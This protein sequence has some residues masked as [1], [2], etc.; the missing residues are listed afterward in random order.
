MRKIITSSLLFL[1]AINPFWSKAQ[2]IIW[3]TDDDA[4]EITSKGDTDGFNIQRNGHL[5]TLDGI[6]SNTVNISNKTEADVEVK[7]LQLTTGQTVNWQNLASG[8]TTELADL[9]SISQ[10]EKGEWKLWERVT[11]FIA[12]SD[13]YTRNQ[14]QN[15]QQEEVNIRIAKREETLCEKA[16]GINFITPLWTIYGKRENIDIRWSSKYPIT[17]VKLLDVSK[18]ETVLSIDQLAFY[19]LHYA[20]LDSDVKEKLI[21]GRKYELIVSVKN[22]D[23]E[24]VSAS[25]RFSLKKELVFSPLMKRKFAKSRF[26]FIWE[27]KYPVTEILFIDE[28]GQDTLF[29]E[30]EVA[31][32]DNSFKLTENQDKYQIDHQN[33]GKMIDLKHGNHYKLVIAISDAI[34]SKHLYSTLL[35]C[36]SMEETLLTGL[37]DD[38]EAY[39]ALL[40]FVEQIQ[41]ARKTEAIIHESPSRL[42]KVK[43]KN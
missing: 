38:R 39:S 41:P 15:S 24:T 23:G 37:Q 5:Y 8:A 3:S 18:D 40:D 29:Y 25:S 7:L 1:I 12:E 34:G 9:L 17:S 2:V 27:T 35:Y 36:Q 21:G 14:V 26:A 30:N 28:D 31:N 16:E 32:I 20:G 43:G 33:L 4:L 6:L 13:Q 42:S 19:R 10:Q 22:A 11:A